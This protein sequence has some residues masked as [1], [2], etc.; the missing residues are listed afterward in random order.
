MFQWDYSVYDRS[1][2]NMKVKGA[3]RSYAWYLLVQDDFIPKETGLGCHFSN[4]KGAMGV[5]KLGL[6]V[7][8]SQFIFTARF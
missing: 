8:R 7:A 6:L 4:N 2:Y 1:I 5:L 3:S